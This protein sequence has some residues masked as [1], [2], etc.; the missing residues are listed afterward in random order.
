MRILFCSFIIATLPAVA[1]ATIEQPGPDGKDT[2]V[3]IQEPVT[4]GDDVHLYMSRGIGDG[5]L[6]IKRAFV[7]FDLTDPKYSG[8][9]VDLAELRLWSP[10]QDDPAEE[11][12]VYQVS[13]TWNESTLIFDNQPVFHTQA[14]DTLKNA[15]D[16]YYFVV[17]DLVQ[18]W[19][20]GV[21]NY[22]V[23]IKYT[24]ESIPNDGFVAYSGDYSEEPNKRPMLIIWSEDLSVEPASFGVLKSLFR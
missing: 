20:S 9:T 3:D 6:I 17:T 23:V 8:I 24:D 21:P 2:F 16:Y 19:V 1:F 15:G 13:N 7:E 14:D 22:G 11:I 12:G 5:G 18:Y 10:Y 4:H